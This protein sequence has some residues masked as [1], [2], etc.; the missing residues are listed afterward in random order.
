MSLD[1]GW[2][3]Q[4]FFS[5]ISLFCAD[6]PFPQRQEAET[7]THRKMHATPAKGHSF[8]KA[9]DNP[10]GQPVDHCQTLLECFMCMHTW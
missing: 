3:G 7:H 4:I 8:H 1:Q 6:L 5:D 10:S 9:P 2:L